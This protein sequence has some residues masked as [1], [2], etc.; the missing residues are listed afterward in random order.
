MKPSLTAHER[1]AFVLALRLSR[2]RRTREAIGEF[3]RVLKK[4]P[5]AAKAWLLLGRL[6]RK[7]G[8]FGQAA[9]AGR[10]AVQLRPQKELPSLLLFHSLLQARRAT[11]AIAEAK[12]FL[13]QV[14]QGAICKPDTIKVYRDWIEER[15]PQS[16]LSDYLKSEGRKTR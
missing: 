7:C 6:Y 10:M 9:N 13:L 2:E 4:Y 8:E 14:E 1:Q 3:E 15:S 12:R 5:H 11:E 16:L